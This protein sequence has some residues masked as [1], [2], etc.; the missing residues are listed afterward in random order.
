[1]AQVEA[2]L[3]HR[4]KTGIWDTAYDAH[5]VYE[6]YHVA[7]GQAIVPFNPGG[8]QRAKRTFAPDGRPCCAAGLA[9]TLHF[10]YQHRTDLIPHERA[11][12][13][14]PLLHPAPTGAACPNNDA[15]FAKGGC[16]TTIATSTGAR[17]RHQLDRESPDCKRL[18]AQRTMVE[19]I[20]SQAEALDILH[21]KLRRGSAIANQNTLIYVLINLRA[22]ARLR[23]NAPAPAATVT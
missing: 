11:K 7:G 3:G 2:G 17:I 1:M 9:M 14:C 18:Y 16:T 23:A 10:T 12:Y 8:R 13:R 20:N 21:P 4:P 6:Y 22:L 19:R 5:Y 15:H